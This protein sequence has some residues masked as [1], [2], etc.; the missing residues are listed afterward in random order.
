MIV[1]H[2]ST[3][4][5][6]IE[7]ILKQIVMLGEYSENR[8]C[9]YLEVSNLIVERSLV[10]PFVHFLEGGDSFVELLV[11]VVAGFSTLPDGFRVVGLAE[12]GRQAPEEKRKLSKYCG[13]RGLSGSFINLGLT[14]PR[15]HWPRLGE[16]P[17][18]GGPGRC[19]AR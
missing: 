14:L 15:I 2:S 19:R 9:T 3:I 7:N 18:S 13:A 5:D 8:S 4:H 6:N 16:R 11:Q 1:V 12:Q 10:L 17:S